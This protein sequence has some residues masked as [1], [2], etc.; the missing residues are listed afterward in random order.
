LQ[1]FLAAIEAAHAVAHLQQ[2]QSA[3]NNNNNSI[4]QEAV[5]VK[6]PIPKLATGPPS[7]M[8]SYKQFAAKNDLSLTMPFQLL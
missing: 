6:R 7:T 2:Q 1:N 5:D 4:N 8:E 3:Q